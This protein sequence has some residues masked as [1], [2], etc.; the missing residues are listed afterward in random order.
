VETNAIGIPA[1]SRHDHLRELIAVAWQW[2]A[3]A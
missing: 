3:L 2:H 1:Q